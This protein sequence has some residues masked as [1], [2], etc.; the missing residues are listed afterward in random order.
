MPESETDTKQ[1]DNSIT[2]KEIT[3]SLY[4]IFMLIAL[5]SFSIW[6]AYPL[7]NETKS[8]WMFGIIALGYCISLI[9][10]F[11]N[12]MTISF[13]SFLIMTILSI[14]H[15]IDTEFKVISEKYV[16]G[17]II[18]EKVNSPAGLVTLIS[19]FIGIGF[20]LVSYANNK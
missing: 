10:Y 3:F 12:H 13:A 1:K 18:R 7:E 8:M 14:N 15:V 6:L 17:L 11:T 19:S 2:A 20:G 5:I 4:F 9:T 16:D